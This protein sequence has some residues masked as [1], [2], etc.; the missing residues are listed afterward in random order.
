MDSDESVRRAVGEVLRARGRIDVL[1]NN[2]GIPGGGPVEEAELAIFRR[3][4][5]T[6]FFGV[7]RCTRAVLPGMRQQKSGHILNAAP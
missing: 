2:A 7:L 3:V 1:V 5:E 4:M 6:Y